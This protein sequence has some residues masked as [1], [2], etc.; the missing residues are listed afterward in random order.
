M[1]KGIGILEVP[2]RGEVIEVCAENRF[3]LLPYGLMISDRMFDPKFGS[4]TLMSWST[5]SSPVESIG[6]PSS[7]ILLDIRVF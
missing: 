1:I 6:E 5:V 7:Y 3:P 2:D 4:D